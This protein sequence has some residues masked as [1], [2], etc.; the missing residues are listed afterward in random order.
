MPSLHGTV[1]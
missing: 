1:R